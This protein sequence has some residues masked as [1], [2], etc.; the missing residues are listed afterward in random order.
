MLSGVLVAATSVARAPRR[1]SGKIELNNARA[2]GAK[3][4]RPFSS[5]HGVC[6][7]PGVV[8]RIRPSK[9]SRR[10][11]VNNESLASLTVPSFPDAESERVR[12][13][14]VALLDDLALAGLVD[15]PERKSAA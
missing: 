4:L 13:D 15:H 11:N 9:T 10:P 5:R 2:L 7:P 6:K 1:F 8:Q 14:V 3:E 12:G